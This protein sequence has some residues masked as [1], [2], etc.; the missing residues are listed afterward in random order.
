MRGQTLT[1][2]RQLS[3][4][5]LQ[6]HTTLLSCTT[7]AAGWGPGSSAG[8]PSWPPPSPLACVFSNDPFFLPSLL[9]ELCFVPK[10]KI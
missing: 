1:L 10:N 6:P 2:L 9:V 3:E 7:G 5:S 4:S 8:L